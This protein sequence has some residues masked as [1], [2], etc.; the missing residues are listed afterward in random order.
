MPERW[1]SRCRTVTLFPP[2]GELREEL[3]QRVVVVGAF[4][5]LGEDHHRQGGEW[6]GS[7]TEPKVGS[8]VDAV[9]CRE[10]GEAIPSLM[11]DLP[12]DGHEHGGA[13]RQPLGK[14][15]EQLIDADR[16]GIDWV[17]RS[18]S[19]FRCRSLLRRGLAEPAAGV[20]NDR[21]KRD[22]K[23]RRPWT[24]FRKPIARVMEDL[25]RFADGGGKPAR[26]KIPKQPNRCK[27]SRVASPFPD[28][29]PCRRVITLASFFLPERRQ[30]S[31][32]SSN[33]KQEN[34]RLGD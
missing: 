27:D 18:R 4:S 34:P 2:R 24:D 25:Q 21:T 33:H 12:I 28:V 15:R 11:N 9:S 22:A 19:G 17:R 1:W 6:L 26:V 8:F 13:R 3:R 31:V 5:S 10:V 32:K 16:P 7:R 20:K 23:Q 14:L 30:S 29:D